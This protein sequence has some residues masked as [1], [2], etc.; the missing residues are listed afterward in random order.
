MRPLESHVL[1]AVVK[2]PPPIAYVK[3]KAQHLVLAVEALLLFK[4]IAHEGVEI[5]ALAVEGEK[6]A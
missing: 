6:Q 3:Y 2:V 1:L 4:G 5:R